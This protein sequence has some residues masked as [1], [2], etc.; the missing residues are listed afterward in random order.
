[1]K[2]PTGQLAWIK[3]SGETDHVVETFEE[4]KAEAERFGFVFD[5]SNKPTET[6]LA[7]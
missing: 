6:V 4:I 1:M 5:E 2:K 7:T 3:L